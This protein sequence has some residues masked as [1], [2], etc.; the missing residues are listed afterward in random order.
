M[1]VKDSVFGITKPKV[2]TDTT[3]W[4]ENALGSC[5]DYD[6]KKR[7]YVASKKCALPGSIESMLFIQTAL[8]D[9][10]AEIAKRATYHGLLM[11]SKVT[12]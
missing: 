3:N 9:N 6:T 8:F 10:G 4:S 1:H 2:I 12:L 11:L 7:V 5:I